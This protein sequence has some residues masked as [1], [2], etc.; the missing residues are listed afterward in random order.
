V[1]VHAVN[2]LV[3]SLYATSSSE[4]AGQFLGDFIRGRDLSGFSPVI[5]RGIRHHRLIDRLTDEHATTA[6]L[7]ARFVPPHRRVAGIVI[8][9]YFDHILARSF[10]RITGGS[11]TDHVEK[12]HASLQ[13]HRGDFPESLQH[14]SDF[15]KQQALFESY[16][17][18][19]GVTNTLNR[20]SARAKVFAPL[21]SVAPLAQKLDDELQV[22][23]ER[24][25]VDLNEHPVVGQYQAYPAS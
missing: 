9:V 11:F 4:L 13:E 7:R 1:L 22:A 3:H 15:A 19:D 2:F 10:D 23:L 6:A 8:D 16:V 18:M 5:Q 12:I 21:A 20:L 25:L 17:H 24:I 14:F